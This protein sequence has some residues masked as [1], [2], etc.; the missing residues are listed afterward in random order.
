MPG[1]NAPQKWYGHTKNRTVGEYFIKP[2]LVKLERKDFKATII[3]PAIVPEV[4]S[5]RVCIEIL[6]VSVAN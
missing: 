1:S 4:K 3:M 6:F 2:S 5:T